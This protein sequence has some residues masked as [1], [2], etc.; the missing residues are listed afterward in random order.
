[1]DN[2]ALKIVTGEGVKSGTRQ[3]G[4]KD[5]QDSYGS[6][7]TKSGLLVVVCDGMGGARGGK[8]ASQLAVDTII[9]EVSD[10]KHSSA[11]KTLIHAI[12]KANEA[13]YAKSMSTPELQGMGTTVVAILIDEEKATTAHVGDSRIYQVRGNKKVFRTFDHSM[14]FELVRRG[15]IT[16]E[17]A[18]LSAE[19]NVILRALGTKPEVEVEINTNIPYL[20]G[21]RFLLCSDGISGAVTEQEICKLVNADKSVGKTVEIIL[22][23]IDNTGIKSGGKHDNLTAVLIEL[24]SNSKIKVRMNRKSKII[25]GILAVC[26]IASMALNIFLFEG[27]KFNIGEKAGNSLII[28]S[29]KNI[30]TPPKVGDTVKLT[31]DSISIDKNPITIWTDNI[32]L[33]NSS[34]K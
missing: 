34:A 16:E 14:V 23:T 30:V 5:N 13:V 24:N 26:F 28:Y 1:M 27:K 10:S 31:V 9:S 17:Q 33:N 11:D 12:K 6:Q 8:T 18:R 22:E 2:N 4:R 3:G 32:Y 7:E 19:S 29:T 21:D 20:K 25:I 15:R